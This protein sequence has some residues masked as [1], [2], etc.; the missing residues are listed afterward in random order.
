MTLD[1]LFDKFPF[2]QETLRYLL[3][4]IQCTHLSFYAL[5]KVMMELEFIVKEKMQS[6]A[7][8]RWA[9]KVL[10]FLNRPKW[11]QYTG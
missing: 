6:L 4:K 8:E 7:R 2:L 10:P 3:H 11:K 1:Q 5:V 9:S